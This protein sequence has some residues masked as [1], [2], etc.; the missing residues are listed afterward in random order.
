[1]SAANVYGYVPM[2]GYP[3]GN[4]NNV[5]P[6]SSNITLIGIIVSVLLV[7]LICLICFGIYGMVGAGC[8]VFG[9]SNSGNQNGLFSIKENDRGS[10]I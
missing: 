6:D 2:I 8:Y 3:N 1:M 4:V 5:N 10:M 7:V 9:K